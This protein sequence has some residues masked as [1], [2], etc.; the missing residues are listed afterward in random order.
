METPED[1]IEPPLPDRAR[2][3]SLVTRQP[4]L[5]ERH[6]WIYPVAVWVHRARRRIAWM[7][8]D[9]A[10][11]SST[12]H[13]DLAVRVKPHNSLLLRQLGD[14]EMYLQHNKV[15]N[16]MLAAARVDGL[17]IKEVVPLPVELRWRSS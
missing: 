3:H 8:A 14:S 2:M 6:A 16:L 7:R 5:S 9:T 13:D 1:T 11:A 10:W 15:T 17:L 12:S 4:R